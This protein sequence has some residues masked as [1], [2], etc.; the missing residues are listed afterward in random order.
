VA[1]LTVSGVF[2][3]QDTDRA[4]QSLASSLPVT[5]RYRTTF[6]VKG[7]PAS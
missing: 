5:L 4:L 6:W 3:L 2:S 1:D 7:A